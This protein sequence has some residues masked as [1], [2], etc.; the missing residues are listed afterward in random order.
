VGKPFDVID[1]R[2]KVNGAL[3]KISRRSQTPPQ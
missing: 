1:L 2:A 3:A